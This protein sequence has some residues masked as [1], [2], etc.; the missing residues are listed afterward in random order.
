MESGNTELKVQ[1]L[2]MEFKDYKISK[3]IPVILKSE[4]KLHLVKQLQC[5]N[6]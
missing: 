6:Y 2:L 1:R 4:N 3:I 5:Q